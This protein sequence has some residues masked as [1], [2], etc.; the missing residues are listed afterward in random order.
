MPYGENAKCREAT[1]I[2]RK[3]YKISGIDMT[4]MYF[5]IKTYDG[6]LLGNLWGTL[7]ELGIEQLKM[8]ECEDDVR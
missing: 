1:P 5:E 4:G 2:R 6:Y 7:R 3:T 8:E